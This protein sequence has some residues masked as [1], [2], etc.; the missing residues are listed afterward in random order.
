LSEGDADVRG[1]A[2]QVVHEDADDLPLGFQRAGVAVDSA[3]LGPD[4]SAAFGPNDDEDDGPGLRD[5]SEDG[6]VVVGRAGQLGD[7]NTATAKAAAAAEDGGEGYGTA[8]KAATAAA[9]DEVG[10]DA[11][12]AGEYGPH[13]VDGLEAGDIEDGDFVPASYV[14]HR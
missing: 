3:A 7:E 2:G 10:E 6:G 11:D 14:R 5:D 8:A 9:E 1:I 12:V 13:E 4:D